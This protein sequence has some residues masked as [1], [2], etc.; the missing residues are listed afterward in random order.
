ML[1]YPCRSAGGWCSGSSSGSVLGAVVIDL[2]SH[3]RVR[4]ESTTRRWTLACWNE[5]LRRTCPCFNRA[6]IRPDDGDKGGMCCL[7]GDDSDSPGVLG[8]KDQPQGAQEEQRDQVQGRHE[9]C[10]APGCAGLQNVDRVLRGD[11]VSAGCMVATI[12]E[13]ERV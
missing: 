13:E 1:G 2:H 9:I 5:R 12:A 11:G 3:Y 7:E 10:Q 4:E 6:L 8:W